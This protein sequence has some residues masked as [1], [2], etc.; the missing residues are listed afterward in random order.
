MPGFTYDPAK[1]SFK[2][3]LLT[4]VRWRILDQLSKRSAQPCEQHQRSPMLGEAERD[5]G[6]SMVDRVPDPAGQALEGVWEE[7]WEAQ[8][9]HA[10]LARTARCGWLVTDWECIAR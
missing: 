4:V 10:A 8:V 2:G 9:L 6:T 3:W 7:E 1:D 5:T